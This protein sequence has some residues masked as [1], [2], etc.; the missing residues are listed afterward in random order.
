M[1][2]GEKAWNLKPQGRIQQYEMCLE[3]QNSGK[4]GF[5]YLVVIK[6]GV[7]AS[8]PM[9]V[10]HHFERKVHVAGRICSPGASTSVENDC[11]QRWSPLRPS[12]DRTSLLVS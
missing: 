3:I 6:V 10:F 1:T 8:I 5:P 4:L 2:L 7:R 12:Y 9:R 11:S